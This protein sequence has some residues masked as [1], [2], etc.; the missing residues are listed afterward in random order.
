M[1][2]DKM[3]IALRSGK[4]CAEPLMNHYKIKGSI[5]ASFAIYNSKEDIDKL[6]EGIKKVQ[7]MQK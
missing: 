1:I 3:G 5:R 7:E 4:H 2:I 6:V